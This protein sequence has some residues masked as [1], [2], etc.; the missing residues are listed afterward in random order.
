M[1]P[2][3][4]GTKLLLSMM[5]QDGVAL[6]A[7]VA[8]MVRASQQRAGEGTMSRVVP[9]TA[10]V[11]RAPPAAAAPGTGT[12]SRLVPSSASV[13]RAPLAAAHWAR[14]RE[15]RGALDGLSREGATSSGA[16]HGHREQRGAIDGIRRE[17]TGTVSRL[18]P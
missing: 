6:S 2:T 14:H 17:G 3:R 18:V 15:P 9:S 7:P 12:V 10:S 5:L 11:E 4:W 13:E 16:G 8:S 1:L